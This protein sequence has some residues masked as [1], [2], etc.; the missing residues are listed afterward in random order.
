[1][2][3]QIDHWTHFGRIAPLLGATMGEPHKDRNGNPTRDRWH[4]ELEPEEVLKL[5]E[6]YDV[7]IKE[8]DG[9]TTIWLDDKG[10]GFRQ[11]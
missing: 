6:E 11:R 2:K 1:M 8:R 9:A 3:Y 7:M 10:R 4:I 5:S